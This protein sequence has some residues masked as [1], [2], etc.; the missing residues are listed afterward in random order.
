[1]NTKKSIKTTRVSAKLT[2]LSKRQIKV[3]QMNKYS[4]NGET[5]WL[6]QTSRKVSRFNPFCHLVFLLT[7]SQS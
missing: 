3:K 1:M 4:N 5:V 7:V 6:T 2:S